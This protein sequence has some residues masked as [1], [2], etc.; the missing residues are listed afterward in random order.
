MDIHLFDVQAGFG[1]AVP[2]NPELVT[3][4]CL[5]GEMRRHAIAKALVRITPE[6][7]DTDVPLSNTK[8]FE[9]CRQNAGFIPCPIIVPA[10]GG[11]FPPEAEQTDQFVK[12]GAGAA[13]IRPAADS[14][15]IADWL[16]RPLFQALAE[17]HLPVICLERMVALDQVAGIARQNPDLPVIVAETNY[18]AQRLLLPLLKAFANVYLSIGN[19]YIVFNGI[20]QIANCVGPERLLFGTGFPDTEP[21][22][23]IGLLIYS[24]LSTA[25]KQQVGSG[26]M[27]RLMENIK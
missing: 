8:L 7:L 6:T 13:I 5:A 3:D 23:T 20:E 2:G 12:A 14:W 16:S 27:E 18:R 26:N 24:A 17:R 22:S 15:M 25:A 9:A 21:A 1:G 19:N 11:D 10:A 4:E